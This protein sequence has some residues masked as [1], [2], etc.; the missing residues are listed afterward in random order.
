MAA[1][2]A[3]T[4]ALAFHDSLLAM[5]AAS[6]DDEASDILIDASIVSLESALRSPARHIDDVRMKLAAIMRDAETGLVEVENIAFIARDLDL[7]VGRAS[8]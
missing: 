5:A 3:T 8:Q 4:T 2:A 1:D 6:Q 7:L